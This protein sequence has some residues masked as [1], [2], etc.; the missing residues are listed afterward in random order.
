MIRRPPRSTLFP[1]TTL[2]RSSDR[3]RDLSESPSISGK[4]KCPCTS[5]SLYNPAVQWGLS[6]LRPRCHSNLWQQRTTNRKC[7]QASEGQLY[8]L[9]FLCFAL[10]YYV[11]N[12]L[13]FD[14]FA[15]LT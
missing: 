12:L 11:I 8:K 5:Q 6:A 3:G 14:T 9:Q 4:N 7:L 15:S 2:F 13:F 10:F 1:Y